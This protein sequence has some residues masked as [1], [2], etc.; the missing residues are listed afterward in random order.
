MRTTEIPNQGPKRSSRSGTKPNEIM[1]RD[2]A[3]PR[4]GERR[5]LHVGSG[6]WRANKLHALFREAPWREVRL[7]LDPAV[8]PDI[9]SDVA[10]MPNVADASVS[11]VWCSH[12]LE[13]LDEHRAKQ[14]LREFER[15][16]A[17]DGFLL[18][19]SPDLAAVAQL[20]V[21]GHEDEVVYTSPAGGVRPLD[22]LY[23]FQ[24]AIAEGN[25][26]MRHHTGFT[27]RRLGAMMQEAGFAESR[28]T[29]TEALDIW[30]LGMKVDTPR[31][32]TL[33]ALG[34]FKLD[35][36]SVEEKTRR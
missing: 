29:T 3:Q 2:A 26:F 28:T 21:A 22:M 31:A 25:T 20:I 18:L 6:P 24:P 17:H 16:L 5:V 10:Q 35:F 30:A 11:A 8:R 4:R 27:S 19:T 9:V 32:S 36:R 23:G 7:D 1:P 14:A 15:V 34:A 33:D 13:H 12:C